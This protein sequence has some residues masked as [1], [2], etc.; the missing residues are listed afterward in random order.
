MSAS[1]RTASFYTGL[2]TA[3]LAL[4]LATACSRSTLSSGA[5]GTIQEKAS[6]L[7]Y[8]IDIV[9]GGALDRKALKRLRVGL[10]KE[11]VLYLLGSP[12][13]PSV[14]HDGRWD[15]IFYFLPRNGEKRLSRLTLY[16]AKDRLVKISRLQEKFAEKKA[17]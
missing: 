9:Q 14:F 5:L 15:Y 2:F 16:F 17:G 3:V 1:N 6:Q 7:V 4:V 8:R 11:Q 13:M 10:N 12:T